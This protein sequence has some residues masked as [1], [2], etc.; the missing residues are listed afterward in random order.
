MVGCFQGKLVNA[1][2][3]IFFGKVAILI[4]VVGVIELF[5]PFTQA[6]LPK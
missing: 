2:V 6:A 4:Q 1:G 3:K 5:N